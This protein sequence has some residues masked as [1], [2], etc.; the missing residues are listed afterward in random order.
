VALKVNKNPGQVKF[1]ELNSPWKLLFHE[2]A[3]DFPVKSDHEIHD[4]I[5]E[6]PKG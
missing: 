6:E 4:W 2:V 1:A 5:G 3:P